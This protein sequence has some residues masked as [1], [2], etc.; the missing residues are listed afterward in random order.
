[1]KHIV[2]QAEPIEFS[3][4]KALA[5]ADWQPSYNALS[6][7]PKSAQAGPHEGAGVSATVSVGS[8]MMTLISSISDRKAIRLLIQAIHLR[9]DTAL[10][11]ERGP[12]WERGPLALVEGG[13]PS[14]PGTLIPAFTGM[15]EEIVS[16]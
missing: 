13:T 11:R 5:S 12:S 2:K 16:P 6:G 1:M 4:W 9:R 15:M 10:S 8:W 14:L 3:Q 7:E